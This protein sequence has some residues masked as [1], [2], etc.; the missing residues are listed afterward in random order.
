MTALG[1]GQ[2]CASREVIYT[3]LVAA[4]I[5]NFLKGCS[6]SGKSIQLSALLVQ[7]AIH[8]DRACIGSLL[9]KK[10]LTDQQLYAWTNQGYRP[11]PGFIMPLFNRIWHSLPSIMTQSG[12]KIIRD[13]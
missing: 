2:A 13:L 8:E 9:L 3:L 7:L 10:L 5:I 1:A 11:L 6:F 4:R 12:Q